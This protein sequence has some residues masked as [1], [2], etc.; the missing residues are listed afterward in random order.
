[1]TNH[2]MSR[3]CPEWRGD[4]AVYGVGALDPQPCAAVRRHLRICPACQAE[5]ED[6]VP[7]VG[8]LALVSP[9]AAGAGPVAGADRWNA[10]P[11]AAPL[12]V[13]LSCAAMAVT[14]RS[15]RFGMAFRHPRYGNRP[16]W[17]AK[18]MRCRIR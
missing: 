1:V 13:R 6:L 5:Y 14:S 7:V 17:R 4:L 18:R 8:W 12:P 15:C 11:V 10:Q 3:A 9:P 2:Q 16:E